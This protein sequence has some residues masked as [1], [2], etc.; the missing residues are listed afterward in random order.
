LW[1][2]GH[3]NTSVQS[4]DKPLRA[5]VS[6][7]PTGENTSRDRT[8]K[9]ARVVGAAYVAKGFIGEGRL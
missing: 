1:I 4:G 3:E 8:R 2:I 7:S 6:T 9:E 5:A